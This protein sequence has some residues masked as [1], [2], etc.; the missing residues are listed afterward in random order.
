VISASNGDL[1]ALVQT[2]NFREDLY[3]RLNVMPIVVPALSERSEDIPALVEHACATACKK[4]RLQE[5]AVTRAALRACAEAAWPG[6]IRELA[7]AV[8]AGV[9]RA[10]GERSATLG[11]CHIFPDTTAPEPAGPLGFQAATREFQ[12]RYVHDVL[13]RTDWNISEAAKQLGVVRSHVYNLINDLGLRQA[14]G[15]NK[16]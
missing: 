13:V 14:K 3:Y 11:V 9:I 4:H 8:E 1:R 2:R 10:S 16:V 7:N 5:L 15:D 6:N 12:R